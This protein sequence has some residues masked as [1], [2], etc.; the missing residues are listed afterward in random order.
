MALIPPSKPSNFITGNCQH[1]ENASW[2]FKFVIAIM[3][4]LNIHIY[5]F[6][7]GLLKIVSV[8]PYELGMEGVYV[9]PTRIIEW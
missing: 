2:R 4:L 9:D 8:H 3:K 6:D 5:V 1:S 7:K